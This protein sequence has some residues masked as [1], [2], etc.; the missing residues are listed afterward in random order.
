MQKF[1]LFCLFFCFL[2]L[3][4]ESFI[5]KFLLPKTEANK[6]ELKNIKYLYACYPEGSE[7]CGRAKNAKI[8]AENSFDCYDQVIFS[9]KRHFI[10]FLFLTYIGVTI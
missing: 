2:E 4:N 10:L 7:I 9:I 3:T 8:S 1:Y 5:E 6:I